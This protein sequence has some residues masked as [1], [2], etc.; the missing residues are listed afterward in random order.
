ML[1]CGN[2]SLWGGQTEME[3]ST[4]SPAFGDIKIHIELE[5][6]NPCDS[7]GQ[8][9]P[10]F[11]A[12]Y[13]GRADNAQTWYCSEACPL[14]GTTWLTSFQYQVPSTNYGYYWYYRIYKDNSDT[15]EIDFFSDNW[16]YYWSGY[17]YGNAMEVNQI[18]LGEV[19]VDNTPPATASTAYSRN[20]QYENSAGDWYW[21]S[22]T[23]TTVNSNPPSWG[24]D[25]NPNGGS[26]DG[27][28]G[29]TCWC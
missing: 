24:W 14:G 28:L 13:V 8:M 16:T 27:G 2:C 29:H 25:S 5:D 17:S 12:G 4:V 9:D 6:T 15:L 18:D 10:Y 22:G 21:L 19:A 23:G 20:N 1:W 11:E 26:N 7:C 3:T